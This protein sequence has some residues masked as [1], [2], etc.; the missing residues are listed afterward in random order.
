MAYRSAKVEDVRG[1]TTGKGKL[2]TIELSVKC[3]TAPTSFCLDH[4]IIMF[5]DGSA[6]IFAASFA[7]ITVTPL[8]VPL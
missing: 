2:Y 7:N 1:T 6:P 5:Q 4:M 3:Q 8:E